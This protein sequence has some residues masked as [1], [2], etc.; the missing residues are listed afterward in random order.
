MQ[1][2]I[3]PEKSVNDQADGKF[4]TGPKRPAKNEKSDADSQVRATEDASLQD[5]S[6]AFD[7]SNTDNEDIHDVSDFGE[8]GSELFDSQEDYQ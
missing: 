2:Q 5:D 1:N 8:D 4:D 3:N 6:Y 7:E